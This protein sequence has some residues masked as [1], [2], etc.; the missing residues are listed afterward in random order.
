MQKNYAKV[1]KINFIGDIAEDAIAKPRKIVVAIKLYKSSKT[2][3][4]T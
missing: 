4:I 2:N 1:A 3:K